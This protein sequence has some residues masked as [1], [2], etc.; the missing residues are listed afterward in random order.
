MQRYLNLLLIVCALAAACARG[1]AQDAVP[2]KE[3]AQFRDAVVDAG[4]D[5]A[6]VAAYDKDQIWVIDLAT[7]DRTGTVNVGRGP[8]ALARAGWALACVN[9]L[10]NTVSILRLP[11]MELT[12]TVTVGEGPVAVVSIVA[13]GDKFVVANAFSDSLSVIDAGT[14]AVTSMG[15][16]PSVPSL[17]AGSG[18]YVAVAGKMLAGV[19]IIDIATGASKTFNLDAI[20]TGVVSVGNDVFAVG[21][22]ATLHFVTFGKST[23]VASV[24]GAFDAL[25][26]QKIGA[27][28]AWPAAVEPEIVPVASISLPEGAMTGATRLVNQDGRV[29]VL[30]ATGRSGAAYVV[31]GAPAPTIVAEAPMA[32]ED[33]VVEAQPVVEA[34]PIEKEEPIVEAQPIVEAAP[35]EGAQPLEEAQETPVP[36]PEA[37]VVIAEAQPAP[38]AATEPVDR[39]RKA[40]MPEPAPAPQLQVAPEPAP[41]ATVPPVLGS[42]RENPIRTGGVRAPKPGRN[43]PPVDPTARVSKREIKETLAKPTEFGNIQAGFEPP[44]YKDPLRDVQADEMFQ[45]L[46]SDR[47]DLKGNVRLKMGNMDFSSDAFSYS[48]EGGDF[49]AMGNVNMAQ[50]GSTLTADDLHYVIPAEGDTKLETSPTIFQPAEDAEGLEE[51]RVRQGRLIAENLHVEEPGRALTAATVD[52][53]FATGTGDLTDAKGR[54]DIWYFGAQKLR[55]LGPASVGGEDVWVTTCDH[56]PPHYR[57]KMKNLELQEDGRV[58]AE[59]AQLH[60]GGIGTPFFLPKWSNGI[61]GKDWSMDFDSGRRAA[62]GFYLNVGQRFAVSPEVGFGPRIFATAKEGVGLGADLDYNFTGKPASRLYMNQGEL[63]TL[64]TSEERG[65]FHWY[66]RWEQSNELVI[67][68]QVEQ[69]GDQNFYKDFFYDQYRNR[70]GPRTF[71]SVTYQQPGYIAE[72]VVR[73]NTHSWSR[74]TERLPGASFSLLERPIANRLYVSFDTVNGYNDRQPTGGS[75]VRTS[76]TARLSYDANIGTYLNITPYLEVQDV[77]YSDGR[78]GDDG[79]NRLTPTAGINLQTRLQRSYGGILGFSGFKHIIVPSVTYLYRPGSTLDYE[80]TPRFD[81]LDNRFGLS[82]IETKLDNVFYGRDAETGE[83]WQVGRISLYQGNDFWNEISKAE[84]YEVEVDI[85]PRPWWGYQL[86]GERHV[87]NGDFDLTRARDWQQLAL[88]RYE[89]VFNRPFDP[90][91]NRDF[92]VRFGDYNRILTQLYYDNTTIGGNWSARVGYAYTSTQ[93]NTYNREFL[94]GAGVKLGSNWAVAFE[95][96]YD[97]EDNKLRTQ[98][99]EIRRK[100]HCWEVGLLFRDRESGFD[101]DMTFNITAFPGSKL[102]I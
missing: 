77:W 27:G 79:G 64:Y 76:N 47:T 41:A 75:A 43:A 99:Y 23:P 71:A 51:Q 60:F 98:T 28:L 73:P 63:H 54:A 35:V 22:G 29:I 65:Y 88:R 97:F 82:R 37:Q 74:D 96:R 21:T 58:K 94:Y 10:D 39:S 93:G 69:W 59:S 57:I 53:D 61:G 46:N 24:P 84:D 32:A 13:A 83:T 3:R 56:D 101:M 48:R 26:V 6:Y 45:D 38:E 95:H 33:D 80:S 34:A 4:A 19:K 11:G 72:G 49:H 36:A 68:T 8:V 87:I 67:R 91:R 52:Y 5:R 81:A 14:G 12:N 89:E 86:V 66:N 44:D 42:M 2:F 50:V 20:P 31:G 15:E 85:R 55:I 7:G 100:L 62:L 102:K 25:E 78:F 40:P 90:I 70:T 92:E 17:L 1:A 9:R 18:K 30:T 16:V